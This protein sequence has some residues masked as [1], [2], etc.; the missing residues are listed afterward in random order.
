M[1]SLV[2]LGILIASAALVWG[3][4]LD[5]IAIP[6]GQS[7]VVVQA[8]MRPDL[9]QQFVLIERSFDGAIEAPTKISPI[10]STEPH[11]PL[12][13]ATVTVA[14][15]DFP[16]DPC[17]VPVSFD[18]DALDPGLRSRKGL[19]WGPAGCP[20]MRPGD[21]LELRVETP[22]GE[23]VIGV[24]RVPGLEGATLTVAGRTVALGSD[25]TEFNRDRDTLVIAVN[26]VHHRSVQIMVRRTG[27]AP[28][29]FEFAE[30]GVSSQTSLMVFIDSSAVRFPGDV[31]N[32]FE[33][34]T[35]EETFLGGRRYTLV[36]GAADSNYF[37]FVRSR[38]NA[39]T[40]RGFVN[41]LQG[42]IGVF[43][44]LV[45]V[46]HLLE[47]LADADDPR[48]GSYRMQGTVG[49][50]GVDFELALY[51][52]RP[53]RETGFS[54]FLRGDWVD[55]DSVGFRP[56]Q[57]DRQ[58]VDGDLSGDTLHLV[59]PT[60]LTGGLRGR[61]GLL[62]IVFTG[63]LA[64]QDTFTIAVADSAFTGTRPIGTLT[65]SRP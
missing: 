22:E 40:G 18:R 10:P 5:E 43:G 47:V 63:I 36:V 23:V 58:S 54:A 1:R 49:G 51:L 11:L 14:N 50:V 38:N 20:T 44:S 25:A 53:L 24:S 46:T 9:P 19:Y 29:G 34:G 33:R 6:A 32:L 28:P 30:A 42:G 17:G 65:A 45:A 16:G 57:I 41:R 31:R 56:L 3:C 4:E 2:K 12:V 62:N 52:G 26:A 35:G 7:V 60:L 61:T 55:R 15:L 59:V 13:G 39:L 64:Q 8:V 48:E 37:D 27:T 21:R